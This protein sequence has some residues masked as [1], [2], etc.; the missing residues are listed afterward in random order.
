MAYRPGWVVVWGPVTRW[1]GAAPLFA[2]PEW[3]LVFDADPYALIAR[4][5]EVE[6]L[7]GPGKP[8]GKVVTRTC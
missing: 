8:G 1:Y 5:D 4:M 3:L 6:R 7:F 2:V